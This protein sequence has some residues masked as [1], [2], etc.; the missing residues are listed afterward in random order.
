VKK[1]NCL[2]LEHILESIINIEKFTK[3]KTKSDF[4][5]SIQLQ[6]AIIRRLEIIG[7]A[8]KNL[9]KH[10]RDKYTDVRWDEMARMRDK[11][12]HHYFRVDL[13]ITWN[14][15]KKDFP[16]LKKSIHSILADLKKAKE[17]DA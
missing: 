15:I 5:N 17:G 7:E 6:D 3:D 1:D 2:F 13:N 9:P 14:V 8:T 12:I 11:L 10:F 16:P 4:L